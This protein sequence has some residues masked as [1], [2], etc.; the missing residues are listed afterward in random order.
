[1][2]ATLAVF[3]AIAEGRGRYGPHAIGPYIISMA[4]GLDDV[5]SVLLLARWGGLVGKG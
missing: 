1:M 4:Q 3:R 2:R 5:L